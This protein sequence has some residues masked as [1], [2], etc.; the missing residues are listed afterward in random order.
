MV[1]ALPLC[2]CG[3]FLCELCATFFSATSLRARRSVRATHGH[4]AL[5]AR[6]THRAIR[7]L[8]TPL[9]HRNDR[10]EAWRR[11]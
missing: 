10:V 8:P 2:R 9:C 3:A 6:S 11:A 7:W 4:R 1:W 5:S